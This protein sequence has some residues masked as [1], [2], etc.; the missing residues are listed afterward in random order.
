MLIESKLAHALAIAGRF[1]NVN[2]DD[3]GEYALYALVRAIDSFLRNGRDGNIDPYITYVVRHEIKRMLFEDRTITISKVTAW[4]HRKKGTF[5][6]LNA[7][8][9]SE[10]VGHSDD[11]NSEGSEQLDLLIKRLSPK[12]AMKL[13]VNQEPILELREV[14]DKVLNSTDDPAESR[15]ILELRIQGYTDKE[16]AKTIDRSKAYVAKRRSELLHLIKMEISK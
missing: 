14:I 10:T 9:Y 8:V 5:E 13:T 11:R 12:V 4:R 2:R 16:V 6:K 7:L 1:T 3:L 15:L